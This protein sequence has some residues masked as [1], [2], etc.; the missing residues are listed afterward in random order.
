MN[1]KNNMI[2][3]LEKGNNLEIDFDKKII[4]LRILLFMII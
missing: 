1:K 4:F 3:K 2:N